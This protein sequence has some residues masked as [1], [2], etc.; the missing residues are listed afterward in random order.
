MPDPVEDELEVIVP[1]VPNN[2]KLSLETVLNEV[3]NRNGDGWL[4]KEH[5]VDIQNAKVTLKFK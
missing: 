3:V 5:A 2:A 1:I 4:L